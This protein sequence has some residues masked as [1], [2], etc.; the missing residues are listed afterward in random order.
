LG[1]DSRPVPLGPDMPSSVSSAFS[2]PEDFCAAMH[3]EGCRSFLITGPGEFR[4]RLTQVELNV[5]RLSAAEEQLS[6]IAFVAVPADA[7]MIM[8]PIGEAI[9]P[10]CAGLRMKVGEL[11]TLCPGARFHARSDG[12][13]HWGTIR[14]TADRLDQ[15]GIALKGAPFSFAPVAKRWRPPSAAGRHLRS[16]FSSAIRMAIKCPQVVVD[17]K[18]AHGL[19]QQLLHVLVECLAEGST[20]DAR[21]GGENQ[22]IMGRFERL[23]QTEESTNRS[24]PN[25]CA[26]LHVSERC[27]RHL[28]SEHLGMSPTSY[29]RLQRM[30]RA[31]HSL[32]RPTRSG[33][34]VGG[35]TLNG[36]HDL[37]RFAVRYRAAFGESP[38]TTLRQ[39]R[40][41]S[42]G[43]TRRER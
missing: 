32:C 23:V 14:L 4:A 33:K 9:A 8:F 25:V 1:V 34:R 43:A 42:Q 28:C 30:S 20:D 5:M 17:A 31:R 7:V 38:S 26:V 2:E 6:R 19:E 15:Y 35:R 16:L 21:D 39:G 29:A 3:V 37:G 22:D 27:L 41:R 36:F 11:M 40:N 24:L 12:P 13:S 18:A 10:A